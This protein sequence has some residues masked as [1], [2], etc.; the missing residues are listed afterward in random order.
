MNPLVYGL[1][2]AIFILLAILLLKTPKTFFF[3][4]AK[5]IATPIPKPEELP[6]PPSPEEV[7]LQTYYT[8][9]TEKVALDYPPLDVECCPFSKPLSKDLPIA[10]I[11]MCYAS[12]AN[13]HLFPIKK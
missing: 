1:L 13:T 2:I 10:N 7:M 9:A 5:T 12:N 3:P 4:P 11:P 8:P 6:V